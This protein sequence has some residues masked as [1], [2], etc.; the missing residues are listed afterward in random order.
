MAPKY[1]DLTADRLACLKV[2]ET[3]RTRMSH[4]DDALLPFMDDNSTLTVPDIFNQ[5]HDA[6]WLRS[7]HDSRLD[8]SYVELTAAGEE[9][10]AQQ[11]PQEK[12]DD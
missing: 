10:L 11:S 8:C 6:G 2:V 12:A 3:A 5:C 7:W 9:A 4:D 1:N